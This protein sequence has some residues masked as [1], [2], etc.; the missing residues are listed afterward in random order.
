MAVVLQAPATAAATIRRCSARAWYCAAQR[1]MQHIHS[2]SECC[3]QS[4]HI[5]AALHQSN[6]TG[7]QVVVQVKEVDN[8][9]KCIRKFK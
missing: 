4:T 7:A 5:H 6:R 8:S 2:S 9:S 1:T 3:A